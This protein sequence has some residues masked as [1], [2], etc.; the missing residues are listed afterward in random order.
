VAEEIALK[1][2]TSNELSTHG[3]TAAYP[4]YVKNMCYYQ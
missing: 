4:K 1:K 2:Q 3:V